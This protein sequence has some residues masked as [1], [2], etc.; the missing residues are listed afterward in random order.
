MSGK[1]SDSI[2]TIED[3]L[4]KR[5]YFILFILT[6]LILFA[7][8]YVFTLAT[9]TDHS[10]G[11]FVMMNGVSYAFFT[12]LLL[13]VIALLFGVYIALVVYGIKLRSK[14]AGSSVFGA[15]GLIVGAFSAGCPMCG[16]F[17]FGLFGAPLTLFFMP[18]KGLEL[19]VL[20][21][22]LLAISIY[23]LS[24]NLNRCKAIKMKGG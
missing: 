22:V 18:Y 23:A 2:A 11:I 1:I 14:Y 6:S 17:L 13:V 19:R 24:K 8:F 15:G 16:A 5:N 7:V 4:S 3:V 10:I 9:T 12:F 20:A 21:M